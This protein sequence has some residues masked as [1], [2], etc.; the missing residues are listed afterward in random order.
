MHRE[1]QKIAS[2][3]I[4]CVV[5]TIHDGTSSNHD[6]SGNL[7]ESLLHEGGHEVVYRRVIK[8]T[9]AAIREA[10]AE[11]L[12]DEDCEVILACGGIG[13]SHKDEAC[14]VLYNLYQK[15]MEGFGSLLTALVFAECGPAC[16]HSRPS[17]GIIERHPVFSLPLDTAPIR[18][19]LEKLILP[20]LNNL[21]LEAHK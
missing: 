14:D 12:A 6:S 20:E 7:I 16:L 5:L 2:K 4:Q 9:E 18:I 1:N 13:L 17:A 21:V 3:P 15:R 8:Q 10:F 11:A 19:A